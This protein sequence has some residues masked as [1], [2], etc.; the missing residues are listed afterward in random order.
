M[1]DE[2]KPPAKDPETEF[3]RQDLSPRNIYAFLA[4]LAVA[5]VLVAFILLGVYNFMDRYQNAHQPPQNPL[6]QP[7][8]EA[9]PRQVQPE[10]ILK[11]PQPRLEQNERSELN[12]FRLNEEDELD[13]Y[14]W[15]DQKS[16]I[17]RIPI[18]RA[19][20]LIVQQG[21]PT[22]PKAGTAPLAEGQS[23]KEAKQ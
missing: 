13:S 5:C 7:A 21:L 3:E 9:H 4:G 12:N 18:A 17:V 8:P 23:Q 2:I 22:V 16:G 11:F 20:Q 1:S 19:M 10:A 15:V 14:G 6:V